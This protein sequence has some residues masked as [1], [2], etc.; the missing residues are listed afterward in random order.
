MLMNLGH[1]FL[2]HKGFC[3]VY[4]GDK[5]K[6]EATLL[7]SAL[8][9]YAFL[10]KRKEKFNPMKVASR[11]KVDLELLQQRLGYRSTRSLM[12]GDTANFWQDIELRID[13]DP[14]C[15]SCQ[16][17]SGNKRARSK[18]KFKPKAPFKC[19]LWALFQQHPHIF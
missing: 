15:T 19:F 5:K 8:I 18:T 2:S 6:N 12:D 9:K 16:I 14:F 7:H 1:I 3:I 11:K 17:S 4:F 13:P 10:V